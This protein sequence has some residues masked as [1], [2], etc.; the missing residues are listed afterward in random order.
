[1]TPTPVR[2][3]LQLPSCTD[4]DLGA[5]RRRPGRAGGLVAAALAVVVGVAGCA[6]LSGDTGADEMDQFLSALEAGDVA[7][8]AELTSDPVVAQASL[9]ASVEGMGWPAISATAT[10]EG[11]PDRDPVAVEITWDM[12]AQDGAA[13]AGP[14]SVTTRG[15]VR[16]TKVD[17]EWKVQWAPTVL[18]TRLAEGG[19]LTFAEDLDWDTDIVDR[20]GD[21]LMQWT[22]VT[23]VT[24]APQAADSADAVASLVSGAAPTITGQS[25]RDGMAEAGDQTYQVVAL[26]PEDIEPIREQLAAIPGVSLPEQGQ[27]IRSDRELDSPALD[28]L[29]DA[30]TQALRQEGGWSAQIVNPGAEPIDLGGAPAGQVDD[31]VSTLQ[32]SMQRQAQRAVDASGLAASIVAI[33]PS[34][35]GVLAVAQNDAADQQGP[36]SMQGRFPPGSTF[37]IV[38][39]AAALESGVV[40]PDEIVPCPSSITVSGRTIPNDDDFELGPVPLETAF[41][42]S[43][44]TSQ[45]VISDRLAPEAM[46]DTAATL[47]LGVGF[48]APG[49]G[50]DLYTGSVPVTER[51]P[52]RV[53]ASIGQGEVLASPFGMAV[54]T[55]SLANGG[56]MIL[57]HVIDGMPA[58]AN[59]APEP[60]SP[61]VVDTLRRYMVQTVQSGTATAANSVPGLGGK[62]GTAEVGSG[63]SHGWFVGSTGDIAV[64]VL[65]E[66][67]DSSVPAVA[68]AADFLSAAGQPEGLATR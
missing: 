24:L 68:M 63:A 41:A 17:D 62:T 14:R 29:P 2:P 64:A 47:G 27:L 10:G 11:R 6:A 19:R 13:D 5:S 67:A 42:R 39:T 21:P 30:W 28:G 34:T 53:E 52:G 23:A 1:M 55:A 58:V 61:N 33:Q 65:I 26:R 51:G 31:L 50:A 57:P 44:N 37:K 8:A 48:V 49:L 36:V 59:D 16:T 56:R 25:I 66:R 4:R 54:M 12:A 20:T 43:C 40:G 3:S 35:G 9:T 18:D 60:L 46:K 32:V 45:A 7:G 15:E 38:T 22:P